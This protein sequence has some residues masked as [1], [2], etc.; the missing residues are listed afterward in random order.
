MR[1]T[2]ADTLVIIPTYNE[3]E[4]IARMLDMVLAFPERFHV[5]IVDDGSPDGTANI[6]KTYISKFPDQLF[7]LERTEK[8]GLGRAYIAGFNWALARDYEYILEM[9]CDFSHNPKDLSRLKAACEVDGADLSVGSRYVPGGKLE[10]WPY[11]RVLLSYFASVYVRIITFMN[12][13][14]A[15]AGFVCYKRNLLKTIDLDKIRFVGYAFQ[16]EMKYAAHSLGFKI[17]EIPITFTDRMEGN[18]KMSKGIVKEAI[19]GVL[20]MR[21]NSFFRKYGKRN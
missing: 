7:I 10:N 14:D 8:S 16:I 18:S 4:N 21:W 20:K 17:S 15:T 1:Q 2:V 13:K 3:I 19:I 11:N 9:D 5:L 12:V 6:V